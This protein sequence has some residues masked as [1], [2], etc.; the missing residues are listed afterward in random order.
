MILVDTS[1]WIDH[2]H[3]HDAELAR[4]LE[5]VQ[6]CVHPMVIGE[7]ALGSLRNRDV[8]LSLLRALPSAVVATHDE[9][10]ALVEARQLHERGLSLVDA[11]LLASVLLTP[12]TRLFTRDRRLAAS[13]IALGIGHTAEVAMACLTAG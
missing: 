10:M 12:G 6:V 4:L 2:L 9:T 13:A 11:H 1:V 8:V 5:A 7:M 3:R